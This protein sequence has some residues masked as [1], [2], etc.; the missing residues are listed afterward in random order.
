[1]RWLDKVSTVD[2]T[3]SGYEP[4]GLPTERISEGCSEKNGHAAT[5][6][7]LQSMLPM[8][9]ANRNGYYLVGILVYIEVLSMRRRVAYAPSKPGTEVSN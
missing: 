8:S 2:S 7:S 6:W 4:F 1:M 3:V 5:T 9:L